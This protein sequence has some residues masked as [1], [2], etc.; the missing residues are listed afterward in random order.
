[1]AFWS[2]NMFENESDNDVDSNTDEPEI[3]ELSW[4]ELICQLKLYC[5]CLYYAV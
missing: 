5:S 1:M 3:N 2:H 4:L